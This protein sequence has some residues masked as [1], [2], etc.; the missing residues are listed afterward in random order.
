[1]GNLGFAYHM[2]SLVSDITRFLYPQSC[3]GCGY[4]LFNSHHFLCL[5]CI[6][7]LPYTGFEKLADN[8]ITKLFS[9]RLP[10]ERGAAWL[11]FGKDGLTQKLIHQL[12]YHGNQELGEYLG[13]IMGGQLRQAGWFNGVDLIVPL[14]LNRKKYRIRGY[15]QAELICTGLHKA[16]NI[17]VEKLA[18][19]RTIF[20]QTQTRKSRLQRWANVEHVFDVKDE[21]LLEGRHVLLVDDVI[22]TGATMDACG[23]VLLRAPGLK[24]SVLS[25]ALADLL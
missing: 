14:P 7:T 11:F 12:K 5:Q 1:M 18:I 8:N 16:T 6:D 19:M 25:L 10:I 21:H 20:T 22:T 2:A 15:N 13:H 17:Q 24:L 23:Q 9:G 3:I 4:N